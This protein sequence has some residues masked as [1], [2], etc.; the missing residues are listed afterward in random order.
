MELLGRHAH[1]SKEDYQSAVDAFES[2]LKIDPHNANLKANL[3]N[4]RQRL[5][6]RPSSA[7]SPDSLHQTTSPLA[8]GGAGAGGMPDLASLASM[9]G[10]GG[11][12]GRGGMPD[13]ASLMQNPALMQMAQH[14]MQRGGMEELLQNPALANLVRGFNR[15]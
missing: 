8:G 4:A 11:A 3:E 13:L 2:G 5:P 7:S 6:E 12:G 1:Y 15:S 14:F 10:G 9:F